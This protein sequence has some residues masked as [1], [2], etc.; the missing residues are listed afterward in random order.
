M[1]NYTAELGS[2]ANAFA[3]AFENIA[4]AFKCN[5]ATFSAFALAWKTFDF[6]NTHFK[7][8]SNAVNY[9]VL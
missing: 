4:F 3:L 7:Y 1:Q 8:T 6:S 5:R 9:S 2:N